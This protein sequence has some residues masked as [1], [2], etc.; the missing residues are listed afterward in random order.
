MSNDNSQ[1]ET[2]GFQT[3][4]QQL[5]HL[6]IHSLYGHKEIFLR[7]LVSNAS[8]ACDKL[9]FE[10][11]T[12]KTLLENGDELH[13]R[14][15]IDREARTVTVADNGVG[16]N[17][18]EV[19]EN[20]GTIARSGTRHFV[21]ALTGDDA[22]DANLIG[23]FG[24]GFYSVFMVADRVSLYSR[25]AGLP[26]EQGVHWESDGQGQYSVETVTRA[27]RGTEIVLHIRDGE[28]E[29]LE[30]FRLRNI[31]AKYSD[32][33]SLPIQVPKEEDGKPVAGEWET[34]NRGSALWARPKQEIS[35]DEYKSFYSTLTFDDQPPLAWLH[36][37]VEGKLEYTTL[38][39]LPSRAPFDLWDREHRHGVK[40]YVR[41]IFIMDDTQ[42]LLPAYLRF[43][44]GVVDS[45]DLPLN[46]SREFLQ[47]N[48]EIDTIRAAS[49]KKILQRLAQMADNE[50]DQYQAFW[51]EFGRVLKEGFAE[52]HENRALL[53]DLLRFS[54]TRDDNP[55][56]SHSLKDYIG[57]MPMKQE[58]IYYITADGHDAA[59]QSPHLEIFRKKNIEV[60]LLSEP[61]DE[62]VVTHLTEY[63]GKPLRSV[64][65]G[66][67]D[68]K[69]LA[70]DDSSAAEKKTRD[71]EYGELVSKIKEILEAQVKDVRISHRLTD[72][73]ACLVADENDMGGNLERILKAVG[74]DVPTHKPI[75]ELNPDHVLIRQ[76]REHGERLEDWARVLFDQAALS[77]GATIQA[78]ADYVKRINSLIADSLDQNKQTA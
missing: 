2:L 75:L 6:M 4:V 22:R 60:M 39:Y 47:H 63:E 76:L 64:S 17:R 13:I 54:S 33:I 20:I 48:R 56:Q 61:I 16:M 19:V 23:Q 37:R 5:L 51:K 52:D 32:H 28:D 42:H 35:D 50:P 71:E 26:P 78:P 66:A 69:D 77:E 53:A 73:P 21:Q 3:E 15:S 70:D 12:D 10:A 25:R 27:A 11:L 8:D 36:N 49:A 24:V 68:S 45:A 34:V 9:R 29:F 38:F 7:E 67:L 59:A 43:V 55:E 18:E 41:R 72:S 1:K 57:R 58:A 46:V 65:R 14:V 40:L 30:S 74:Q 62:W 31:I 44:R